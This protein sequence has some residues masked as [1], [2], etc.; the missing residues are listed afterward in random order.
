MTQ[1]KLVRTALYEEH[2]RLEAN[3]VDFHGFELPIWYSNIKILKLSIVS[4]SEFFDKLYL[5]FE[6]IGYILL[7]QFCLNHEIFKYLV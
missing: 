2:K 3:I 5:L 7:I 6:D 1:G 4:E